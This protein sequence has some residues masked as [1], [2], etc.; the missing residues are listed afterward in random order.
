MDTVDIEHLLRVLRAKEH[1]L[2]VVSRERPDGK[3]DVTIKRVGYREPKVEIVLKAQNRK[4]IVIG[5]AQR[6]GIPAERFFL[7]AVNE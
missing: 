2:I 3:F 6:F 7:R 5:L 1:N 4:R